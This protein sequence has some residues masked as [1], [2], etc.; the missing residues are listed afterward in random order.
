M[1]L[2]SYLSKL[3]KCRSVIIVLIEEKGH[4]SRPSWKLPTA[5]NNIIHKA[6]AGHEIKEGKTHPRQQLSAKVENF[7]RRNAHIRKAANASKI[8]CLTKLIG[9]N[10]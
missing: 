4:K 5:M 2:N 6:K 9:E 10:T 1:S 3:K 8:N 7:R